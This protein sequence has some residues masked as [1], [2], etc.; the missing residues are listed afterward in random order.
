MLWLHSGVVKMKRWNPDT[1]AFDK[2]ERGGVDADVRAP[3]GNVAKK[4]APRAPSPPKGDESMNAS[5][6]DFDTI[7]DEL[8]PHIEY[9]G[10]D[11][12]R[13]IPEAEARIFASLAIECIASD[14]LH[15]TPYSAYQTWSEA[16]Q[17]RFRKA[18][19]AV[20][21]RLLRI[22]GKKH[23]APQGDA[24]NERDEQ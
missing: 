6:D 8:P 4:N 16:Q 15:R 9:D 13:T 12:P 7:F 10:E 11:F 20:A 23:P 19:V 14:L 3:I 17:R 21:R 5:P 1:G 24:G 18:E 2:V 22:A